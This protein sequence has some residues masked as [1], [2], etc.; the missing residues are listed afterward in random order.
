M[1][2]SIRSGSKLK[3]QFQLA[4][5]AV[6][7]VASIGYTNLKAIINDVSNDNRVLTATTPRPL[8]SVGRGAPANRL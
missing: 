7:I 8:E 5:C 3:K 6:P 1:K 4:M 2:K